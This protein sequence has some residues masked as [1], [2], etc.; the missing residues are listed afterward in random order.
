MSSQQSEP[1]AAVDESVEKVGKEQTLSALKEQ[2][3]NRS[4]FP[5]MGDFI[6]GAGSEREEQIYRLETGEEKRY[7]KGG[8]VPVMLTK[9]EYVVPPE[10]VDKIGVNK[11]T[12]INNIG[13]Y[14]RGGN[15]Y[16]NEFNLGGLV[17]GREPNVDTV[18]TLLPE[19]SY[20]IQRPSV[21]A[22][23]AENIP[24]MIANL[25]GLSGGS[26]STGYRGGTGRQG[27]PNRQQGQSSTN[28][29]PYQIFLV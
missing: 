12:S 29:N 7:N 6:T 11:L 10:Q 24:G 19:G 16:G 2:Q 18:K 4:N 28:G 27:S 13:N 14:N 9:G 3:D 20:V 21:D 1:D 25:G 26:G 5:V 15:V 8:M 17:P 23:G 22:L